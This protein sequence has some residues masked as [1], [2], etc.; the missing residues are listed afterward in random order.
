VRDQL[1]SRANLSFAARVRKSRPLRCIRYGVDRNVLM[2]QFGFALSFSIAF[3]FS[4]V[5]LFAQGLPAFSQV[6]V[7]GDSL[8]DDGNIQHRVEDKFFISFPSLAFDY[9]DGRFTNGSLTFPPSD[10]YE[11]TWHEQLAQTFLGLP[12]ASNSLD[13][14]TNYA[15]GGATTIDGA[16]ERTVISNPEPFLG[17]DLTITI[18]NL[19]KQVDD[20]LATQTVDPNALYIV[21]GGGNDIFDHPGSTYVLATAERVAGL[22]ERLARAGAYYFLV[23]NVPPLG[24]VPN[25]Q[26]DPTKAAA[27]NAGSAEYR[28]EFNSQLNATVSMLASDGITIALYRYDIFGLFYRLAA[29]PEDVAFVNISDTSQGKLVDPDEYLFWDDIHP[30]TAGHYQIAATAFD[31]LNGTTQPPAQAL[32]LSGRLAVGTDEDVLIAGLIVNGTEAKKVL[33]RGLGPSIA[34]GGVPLPGTMSDP[35]LDLYQGDIL[36]LSNDSWKAAQQDEIEA[37][38]LAPEND[39]EAALVATLA[40]GAYTVILRGQNGG[41]GIGLMDAYDLDSG[42]ESTLANASMRG[43]VQT[44]DGV[45]IAGFIIGSGG[46]DT[47]LVRAIGPSL[48]GI[49]VANPLADPTLD[50]YDGNGTLLR[51]N[52]DWRSTQEALIRSTNLAPAN[53]SEAAIIRSLAPGNYT[54]VVR[55][56]DGGTGVALVEVYNLQ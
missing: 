49:G 45:L 4:W 51:S 38:G 10:R 27:L 7:F 39:A 17:G 47:V 23:P 52:D 29:N 18:D 14:G 11:G 19:G 2:R 22:V 26:D 13:G 35:I 56:K 8:S 48:A 25:Y 21:W 54:A 46:N 16:S 44:G 43:F 53:D 24:L 9:A 40:P 42:V 36:L 41:T 20:Y 15:F 37:T 3:W 5:R 50:L 30:S 32:N 6:I 31:L 34:I 28:T 55:G 12:A 33:V 1:H